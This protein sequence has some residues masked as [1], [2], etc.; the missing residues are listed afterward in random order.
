MVVALQRARRGVSLLGEEPRGGPV[1]RPAPARTT[2]RR[3]PTDTRAPRRIGREMDAGARAEP[4]AGGSTTREERER[5]GP[6]AGRAARPGGGSDED[7][8]RP[9]VSRPSRPLGREMDVGVRS[10]PA[11]ARRAR[12]VIYSSAGAVAISPPRDASRCVETSIG[13][14][15]VAPQNLVAARHVAAANGWLVDDPNITKSVDR[16]RIRPLRALEVPERRV[17]L[18]RATALGHL[19]PRVPAV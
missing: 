12:E 9:L 3:S 15:S 19:R 10:E 11:A 6:P 4:A 5:L 8:P 2:G 13:Y 16:P 18:L 17:F 7:P 1:R 14:M